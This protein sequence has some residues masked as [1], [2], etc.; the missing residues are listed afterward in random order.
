[1]T[2]LKKIIV[3]LDYAEQAPALRLLEQLDPAQ[4]RVKVGKQ[5]FTLFGPAWVEKLQKAGFEVFL[6]L[7]YH[8]IPNTVAE[9]CRAAASL[10]VWMVNVHALGGERMMAAARQALDQ[11]T[12]PAPLL[13]AVTLLTSMSAEETHSL[14]LGQPEALV[15]KLAALAKNAG[16][17]GVVCSA[18]EARALKAQCGKDFLLVC[19]GIRLPED[20]SGDQSR[21]MTPDAALN[22]GA[23]YLVMGRSITQ[24]KNPKQVLDTLFKR[25]CS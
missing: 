16:V 9:A 4:C 22:A 5:M 21:I 25:S 23:D 6:D 1:M 10:G 3:A 11:C 15:L 18:H 7:K 8:D 19:P 24:A 17:Q 14:G 12:G 20:D 13:I 2:D